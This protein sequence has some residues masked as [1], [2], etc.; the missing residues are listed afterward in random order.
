M[1]DKTPSDFDEGS[2]S[3]SGQNSEPVT[4]KADANLKRP[5]PLKTL[6]AFKD[7]RIKRRTKR[8]GGPKTEEGK[9]AASKNSTKHGGYSE[10]PSESQEYF[11]YV[12]AVRVELKPCGVIE[13]ALAFSCAHEAFKSARVEEYERKLM[14]RSEQKEVPV[15][16]LAERIGFPWADTHLYCLVN[17]I[18][19]VLLQQRIGKAWKRLA[20]PLKSFGVGKL[21]SM[22][23][24]R[25]AEI[26][27]LGCQVLS[28]RGLMQYMQESFFTKLDTVMHEARAGENYLGLR[29]KDRAAEL[30]L[31]EYWLYRNASAVEA[32]RHDL[33][34]EQAIE[35]LADEN[36][37]RAKTAINSALRNN[38]TSL[39]VLT[40]MKE[41]RS[42]KLL[43]QRKKYVYAPM[44]PL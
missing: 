20:K 18:N 38:I 12:D 31:V 19:D 33:R 10:K 35:V 36:L 37:V 13:E 22:P 17:P 30:F 15:S 16:Q 11:K 39:Q 41:R 21:E 9:L 3:S 2:L 23:D 27:E 42:D 4:N 1:F 43:V 40:S 7:A 32:V 34:D 26:Y 14:R 6:G 28:E 5:E 25:V 24:I 8:S 29:I 44:S